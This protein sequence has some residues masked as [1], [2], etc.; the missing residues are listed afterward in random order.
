[1]KH[2]LILSFLLSCLSGLGQNFILPDG[3]YMDTVSTTAAEC[4]DHRVYYYY[5]VGGKYPENSSSMLK[6][7]WA[8]LKNEKEVYPGSGYISFHF[9]VDC[10]GRVER[11]INVT[12]TDDKYADYHF[13][14]RLVDILFAFFKTLN[15]WKIA[16]N[17]DSVP[18]SYIAFISFKIKDGKVIN[19]IP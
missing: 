14:K 9:R 19:I 11:K 4:R 12:Q 13:D 5:Q 1:M 16:S 2:F 3:E 7:A 15:K 18:V 10:Q 6:E 17:I 8:F